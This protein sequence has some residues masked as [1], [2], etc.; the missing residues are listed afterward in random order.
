MHHAKGSP[1]VEEISLWVDGKDD[2][3]F[4]TFIPLDSKHQS[5][6]ECSWNTICGFFADQISDKKLNISDVW[7]G[8]RKEK[9]SP[10]FRYK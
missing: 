2:D 7:E 1:I 6:Q 5:L 3:H 10:G 4:K 9:G 8:G